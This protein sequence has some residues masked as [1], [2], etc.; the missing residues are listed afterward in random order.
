[1]LCAP[2]LIMDARVE[3]AHDA[4]I[5]A[6]ASLTGSGVVEAYAGNLALPRELE[7]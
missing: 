5:D 2:G 4:E 1:M 7:P 3:P 6:R